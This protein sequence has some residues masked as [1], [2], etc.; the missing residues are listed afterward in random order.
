MA[1]W[2]AAIVG[3]LAGGGIGALIVWSTMARRIAGARERARVLDEQAQIFSVEADQ[4]KKDSAA[5]RERRH[6]AELAR[7]RMTEQ[8]SAREAQLTEQKQMLADAEKRLSDTFKALGSDA[9]RNNNKQF[10]ELAQQT[11]EKLMKAA[12]GDVE[13]KQ[14]AIDALVK[15]I[16][17]LLDKQ[18]LSI[19]ELEKKRESA[20]VRLDEQIKGIANSHTELRQETGRLVTALRRPEV[21]GKWGEVQ[22]RNVVEMAGLQR[23][24]DFDEQ[25][26][27][28]K[29]DISQ[30]PD[31]VVHL[32]GG[33]AIPV[34]AKVTLDAY[35]DALQP[36]ADRETLM[37]HHARQVM[38]Q[39]NRLTDKRYWDLFERSPKVV[40]LFISPES[41]LS[42]ALDVL[43]EI[44]REALSKHVMVA[45]PTT[46]MALLQAAAY[47]WQ[48]ED[49]AAN[50]RHIAQ[51]GKE[52]YDR[53]AT[54]V[55][56]FERVGK[57]LADSTNAYNR[58][59]GSLERNLL[60]GARKLKEL[61]VTT[62]EDV[63]APLPIEIEVRPVVSE[64]LM[65]RLGHG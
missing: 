45:T 48:Q 16:R 47:G 61:H 19:I 40:V 17:E 35:L 57:N 29:G 36:D 34:D 33:G 27:V 58:A 41:A 22:L 13:K 49:V 64:E 10:L 50:S 53:L 21:R 4:A 54:F 26:T 8:L 23:H 6:A 30:R 44:Q 5:E 51:T 24:C 32:P 11:F 55:E 15:P 2:L 3:V 62:E 18:N 25:I 43:P 12:S 31:M 60:P 28:W 42:A 52:L 37:A 1:W 20:Y 9:L 38:D 46:L 14:Q 65:G 56:H 63:E 59:V 7:E 39:V